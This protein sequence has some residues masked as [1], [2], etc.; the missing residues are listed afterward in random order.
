MAMWG[1]I[2]KPRP[3]RADAPMIGNKGE[4]VEAATEA[5]GQEP[6]WE[7][8]RTA[9][10]TPAPAPLKVRA[11]ASS[12]PSRW[13]GV[14]QRN[15]CGKR[16]VRP[17]SRLSMPTAMK[18][19]STPSQLLMIWK[20]W[21]MAMSMRERRRRIGWRNP[22]GSIP[23]HLPIQMSTRHRVKHPQLE[24]QVMSHLE[25][26]GHQWLMNRQRRDQDTG[27]KLTSI[28]PSE[29]HSIKLRL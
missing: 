18:S 12:R 23:Y 13:T 20:G 11:M 15:R 29:P 26:I 8:R 7:A 10:L 1:A 27:S 2:P 14:R 19:V 21:I 9:L 25:G 22:M 24:G 5:T 6:E 17:M 16:M 4:P 3:T 28:C